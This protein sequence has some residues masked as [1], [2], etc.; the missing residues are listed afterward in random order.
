M[1]RERGGNGGQ[2]FVC[3]PCI[4]PTGDLT[5]SWVN[6]LTGN[7]SDTMVYSPA[8]PTWPPAAR[9]RRYRESVAVQTVL[10]GG[11][12]ELRVF[13]FV[14]GACPDGETEYCSNLQSQGSQLI[15]TSYVC[16]GGFTLTFTL[17]E[18]LCPAVSSSGFTGFIITL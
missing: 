5:I 14:A 1:G 8:G 2:S 12:G 6:P 10:H 17:T 4:I 7:G 11:F 13:F 3:S 9:R 15:L 16:G 18:L